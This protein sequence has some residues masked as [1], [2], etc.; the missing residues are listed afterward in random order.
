MSQGFAYCCDQCGR[1]EFAANDE[2]KLGRWRVPPVGWLA[3]VEIVESPMQGVEASGS[4]E[5]HFCTRQCL[6]GWLWGE[7]K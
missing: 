7:T 1:M 2:D 5:R 4:P 3:L 6:L